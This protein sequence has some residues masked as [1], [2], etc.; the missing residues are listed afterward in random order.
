MKTPKKKIGVKKLLSIALFTLAFS[1]SPYL[2]K[3]QQYI[4]LVNFTGNSGSYNGFSPNSTL[5]LSVTGDTLFGMAEGGVTLGNIFLYTKNG[6]Y[7]DLVDF[8]G[9]NGS[10]PGST[11][12]GSL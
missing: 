2:S 4:D 11:P 6:T 8:T 3:A 1:L 9:T 10:F 5:I 7:T 12:Y